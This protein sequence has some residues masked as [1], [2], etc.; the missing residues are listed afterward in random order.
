LNLIFNIERNETISRAGAASSFKDPQV[1]FIIFGGAGAIT[2]QPCFIGSSSNSSSSDNSSSFLYNLYRFRAFM[3]F[4]TFSFHIYI[5][6]ICLRQYSLHSSH[7]ILVMQYT[8]MHAV[9]RAAVAALQFFRSQ[10]LIKW[11]K[12]SVLM[13]PAFLAPGSGDCGSYPYLYFTMYSQQR[14]KWENKKFEKA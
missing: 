8:Y 13:A 3:L 12:L 10:T 14:C 6:F 9:I 4:R 1:S 2:R 5:F 7:H 11:S